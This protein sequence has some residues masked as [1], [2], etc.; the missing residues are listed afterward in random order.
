VQLEFIRPGKPVENSYIESF[1]GRLRDECLN[2][3]TFFDLSDV[4]EKLARRRLDYNQVR[5]HSALADRSPAEFARNWQQSSVASLRTAGPANHT[6]AGAVPRSDT[7]DPKLLQLFVPPSDVKGGPEKLL[8]DTTEAAAENR[9]GCQLSM[10]S[11]INAGN[12]GTNRP[13]QAE[14]LNAGRYTFAGRLTHPSV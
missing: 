5:P 14:I 12:T 10:L 4:R 8:A 1:N 7:T 13:H 6:P 3:E 2:V 11:A 9:E